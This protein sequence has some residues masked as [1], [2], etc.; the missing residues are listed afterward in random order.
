MN[1]DNRTAFYRSSLCQIADCERPAQT[2]LDIEV[3]DMDEN[4]VSEPT[5]AVLAVC[6]IHA[7]RLRIEPLP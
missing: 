7:T 2:F 1:D 3:I 5:T 4:G 6:R